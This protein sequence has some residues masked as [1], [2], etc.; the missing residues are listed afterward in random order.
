MFLKCSMSNFGRHVD[1]SVLVVMYR[2]LICLL[3][4]FLAM[5]EFMFVYKL[6]MLDIE[7]TSVL[8]Y[9][10]MFCSVF[11]L[12]IKCT[13]N[14]GFQLP[15]HV[16]GHTCYETMVCALFNMNIMESYTS[17]QEQVVGPLTI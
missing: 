4:M 17:L 5:F 15:Y 8:F 7:E 11:Q 3:F 14:N 2:T 9:C 16:P 6:C 1:P 12:L 13:C 10:V